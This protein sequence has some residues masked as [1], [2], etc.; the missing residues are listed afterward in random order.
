MAIRV[1]QN[2]LNS[3]MLR[4]LHK[5][6]YS[7][8]T[9]QQQLSSGKKISRPSED[10]VVAT[11]GMFYRSSLM[12]NEQYQRNITEV[13]SWLELSDKA[14]DEAGSILHRV[15]E[16]AVNSGNSALGPDSLQAMSKEIAQ[17]KEHLGSVANQ[18]L[19]GK[20]IFGGSDI[21]TPPYDVDQGKYVSNN[22]S[23]MMLEVGTGILVPINVTGQSV[24]NH[25]G[26]DGKNVF[27]LLDKIVADLK[28]GKPVNNELGNLDEQIDNLL[29]VRSTLGARTN[30]V[31]L[32]SDRME[33]EEITVA[34]GMSKNEDADIAE[35]ITNLKTQENVHR[36][37]LGAG[38]RIIQPSLLDFL[39]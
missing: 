35:V 15:R 31:E 33:R 3:N 19:G 1:T 22:N 21:M 2:M 30:R 34:E 11:R 5:S 10:P 23:E 14:L 16:L 26:T 37:A 38:A 32:I 7:M 39:R 25:T 27:E 24:F 8:D 4:N 28:D 12:E 29:A 17:L 18:T 36:A 9:M 20:F 13:Q 6:M